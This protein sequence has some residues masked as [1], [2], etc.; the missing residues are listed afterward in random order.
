MNNECEAIEL[1]GT[2][3]AKYAG[4]YLKDKRGRVRQFKSE[5]AAMTAAYFER[6]GKDCRPAWRKR[7]RRA[8]RL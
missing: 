1:A 4:G 2:W 3:T 7:G 8:M 6:D 5:R